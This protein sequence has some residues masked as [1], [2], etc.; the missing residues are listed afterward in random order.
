MDPR[1][2]AGAVIWGPKIL[3]EV[4]DDAL[5]PGNRYAETRS[6]L[7]DEEWRLLNQLRDGGPCVICGRKGTHVVGACIRKFVKV[8]RSGTLF[9]KKDTHYFDRRSV[10]A[11]LCSEHYRKAKCSH[12]F[13]KIMR[14]TVP[15]ICFLSAVGF[16]YSMLL[17]KQCGYSIIPVD[18]DATLALWFWI[19]LVGFVILYK[20]LRSRVDKGITFESVWEYGPLKRLMELQWIKGDEKG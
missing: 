14:W 4:L 11:P 9:W 20:V 3:K 13:S 16:S 6:T 15:L 19:G 12:I 17:L 5:K 8:E 2:I 7:T 18:E 10:V 1:D